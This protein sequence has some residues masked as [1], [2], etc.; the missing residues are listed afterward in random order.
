[1]SQISTFLL[2]GR[3]VATSTRSRIVSAPLIASW[4]PARVTTQDTRKWHLMVASVGLIGTVFPFHFT[5]KKFPSPFLFASWHDVQAPGS[6]AP[7]PQETLMSV[8]MTSLK[9]SSVFF[10]V[11]AISICLELKES[12][13]DLSLLTH[14]LMDRSRMAPSIHF[15]LIT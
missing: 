5:S 10:F 7:G 13:F 4:S 9:V 14:R 12:Y 15:I 6:T 3:F 11:N 2:R 1:M 8:A